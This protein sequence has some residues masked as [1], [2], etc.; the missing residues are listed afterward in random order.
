MSGG[1]ALLITFPL[2][3]LFFSFLYRK[4]S[5]VTGWAR[6]MWEGPCLVVSAE[7]FWLCERCCLLELSLLPSSF[8]LAS[9]SGM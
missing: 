8:I 6:G 1:F 7:S 9:G 2:A 5:L 3:F 4:E